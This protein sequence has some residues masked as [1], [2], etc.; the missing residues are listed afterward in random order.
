MKDIFILKILDLFAVL[1]QKAGIDYNQLRLLLQLKFNL[2]RRRTPGFGN[3]TQKPGKDKNL[4]IYTMF[5]YG[6]M[7]LLMSSL[8]I[9]ISLNSILLGVTTFFVLYMIF[10]SLTITME[11]SLDIF[12]ISDREILFPKP[13]DPKVI[14]LAKSL[15]IIIYMLVM[16][17]AFCS[18]MIIFLSIKFGILTGVTLL[19]SMIFCLL[20]LFFCSSIMY[21]VLLKSFSGEKLKDIINLVQIVSVVVVFLGYQFFLQTAQTWLE[22][23]AA[24]DIPSFLYF[25]PPT[26]F[27]MPVSMV[28]NNDIHLMGILISLAGILFSILGYKIYLDKIAPGFERNLNKLEQASKNPQKSKQPRAM[29]YEKYI[30]CGITNSFYKFSVLMLGRERKIKQAIYPMIVMGLFF[31]LMFVYKTISNPEIQLI[32]TKTYLWFYYCMAMLIPSGIYVNFSEYFK[33]AWIYKYLPIKSP[34]KIIKGAQLAMLFSHQ[35]PIILLS[36]LLFLYLWKFTII[37]DILVI[38]MNFLLVQLVYLYMSDPVLPFTEELKTGQNTAFRKISYFLTG[39]VFVP[40]AGGIHF[41]ASLYSFGL[42]IL[43]A[44]QIP[45]FLFLWKRYYNIGWNEIT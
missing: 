43:I 34:G 40:L 42:Y 26:W 9:A 45:V 38:I 28:G 22:N 10:F 19:I 7:G 15:H 27:A 8:L 30:K 44:L 21:G 36:S 32:D 17:F 5:Y 14:N 2:D 35:M 3:I 6:F 12:D 33:A 25:L 13:I 20:F 18:P 1:F 31:P 37:V 29:R 24:T 39:F 41:L 11:F 16:S 23:F 4:F